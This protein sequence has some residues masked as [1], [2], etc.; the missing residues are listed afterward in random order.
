MALYRKDDHRDG[1]LSR[2]CTVCVVALRSVVLALMPELA[3]LGAEG[4]GRLRDTKRATRIPLHG[5][6][7]QLV[8]PR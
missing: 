6:S 7:A 3:S 8:R 4:R 5:W 1:R 2:S